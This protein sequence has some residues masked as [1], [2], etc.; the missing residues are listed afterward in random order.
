MPLPLH[1][2][3]IIAFAVI[4]T[5]TQRIQAS[6]QNASDVSTSNAL[7]V[8]MSRNTNSKLTVWKSGIAA[9]VRTDHILLRFMMRVTIASIVVVVIAR[10]IDYHVVRI[11]LLSPSPALPES[12]PRSTPPARIT[13]FCS[14]AFVLSSFQSAY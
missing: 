6:E 11:P 2:D 1:S 14:K 13:Y 5:V 9:F 4:K 8:R 12:S 3:R 7:Y 10:L